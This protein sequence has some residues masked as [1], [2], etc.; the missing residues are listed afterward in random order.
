V[1]LRAGSAWTESGHVLTNEIGGMGEPRTLSRVWQ[2]WAVKAKVNDTGTHV[3]R[4]F[5]TPTLLASGHASVAY[6][7]A[8][9]GHDPSVLLSTYAVAVAD[10]QRAVSS[11]LRAALSKP[12]EATQ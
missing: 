11:A 6:V 12:R 7:A 4:H 1:Q 2:A 9:L 8:M 3:G 5:A 10:G